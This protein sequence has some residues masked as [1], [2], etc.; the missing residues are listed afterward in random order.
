MSFDT[1]EIAIVASAV[2]MVPAAATGGVRLTQP[3]ML[4]TAA[5]VVEGDAAVMAATYFL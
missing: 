2:A 1:L 4:L 3:V 5:G